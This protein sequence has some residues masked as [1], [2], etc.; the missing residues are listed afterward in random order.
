MIIKNYR[1]FVLFFVLAA[2]SHQ[3]QAQS[4]VMN[5]DVTFVAM[6]EANGLKLRSAADV[7]KMALEKRGARQNEN[8]GWLFLL[9]MSETVESEVAALSVTVLQKLPE[10]IVKLGREEQVF[11]KAISDQDESTYPVEGKWVR[12]HMSEEYIRQFAMI[13]ANYVEL[14]RVSELEQAIEKIVAQF[15]QSYENH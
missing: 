4:W 2:I 11:Y 3:A 8:E 15:Y 10:S 6:S 13:R 7:L 14:I 9:G 12:E 1:S 5:Y